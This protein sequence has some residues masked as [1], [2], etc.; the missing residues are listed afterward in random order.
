M[1]DKGECQCGF[2]LSD[3]NERRNGRQKNA[4]RAKGKKRAA[5]G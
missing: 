1:R 4:K 2:T 3:Q 5:N